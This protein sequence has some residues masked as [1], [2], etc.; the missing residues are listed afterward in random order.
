MI[1]AALIDTPCPV[2]LDDH[3]TLYRQ[4]NS[5]L[6][7]IP[8]GLDRGTDVIVQIERCRSCGLYR[9]IQKSEDRSESELYVDGSICFDASASKIAAGAASVN[10]TDELTLLRTSPPAKLLDV[11]CGAGQFLLRC[12]HLGYEVKGVEL[13]PMSVAF[14]R[15]K[16]GLNVEFGGMDALAADE[17]FNVVSALGVLEHMTDPV[18]FLGQIKK[19]LRPGGEILIGVPNA[20]SLNCFVSQLSR[21]NWDMFLEPGHHYSYNKSTLNK[22][23]NKAGLEVRKQMT[24]TIK[25]RGK[26]PFLPRRSM[27][28]EAFVRQKTQSHSIFDKLYSEFLR[29]LDKFKTGDILFASFGTR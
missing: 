21:H 10:S 18:G 22:L 23:A 27:K 1:G 3:F 25:I 8:E 15:D 5:H 14:V 29:G 7:F 9:S 24:G 4:V 28:L 17:T 20:G 2:C 19:H 11:G 16:L 12:Q 13:D 26:V 6:D